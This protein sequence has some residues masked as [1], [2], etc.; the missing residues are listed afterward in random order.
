MH[1]C[2]K[3]SCQDLNTI[4]ERR[5]RIIN[6]FETSTTSVSLERDRIFPAIFG[7]CSDNLIQIYR[8]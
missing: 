1:V 4:S 2:A 3:T 7:R 5:I 6:P 8:P